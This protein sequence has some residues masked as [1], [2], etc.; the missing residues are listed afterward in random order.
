MD[1]LSA[2]ATPSELQRGERRGEGRGRKKLS[3]I[4]PGVLRTG[5]WGMSRSAALHKV[6]LAT[7]V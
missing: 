4:C 2:A 1:P 3:Q 6:A 5:A 7:C